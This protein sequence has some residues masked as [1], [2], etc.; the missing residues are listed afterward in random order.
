MSNDCEVKRNIAVLSENAYG[1]KKELNLISWYG[2][3]AKYDI[4]DWNPD[5]TRCGKG[6]TITEEELE[7]LF[8]GILEEREYKLK[9][10][11]EFKNAIYNAE[12]NYNATKHA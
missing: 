5:H 8:S 12:Q 6:I 10:D 11:V 7:N 1:W 3:P 9:A 4:R 2:S